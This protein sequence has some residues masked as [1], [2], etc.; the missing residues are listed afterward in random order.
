MSDCRTLKGP[1]SWESKKNVSVWLTT[2]TIQCISMYYFFLSLT[3]LPPLI[4]HCHSHVVLK[5]KM[6]QFLKRSPIVIL[7]HHPFWTSDNHSSQILWI[8]AT[9]ETE[10][11]N[12]ISYEIT[13]YYTVQMVLVD[14]CDKLIICFLWLLNDGKHNYWSS[15]ASIIMFTT[16]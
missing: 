5:I 2:I 7:S 14:L 3:S 11:A 9:S 1:F 6:R 4:M 12:D 10:V 13:L 8:T 16:L 15:L